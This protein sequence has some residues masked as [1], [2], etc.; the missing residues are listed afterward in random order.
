MVPRSATAQ[1][2]AREA[3]R[4]ILKELDR[5]LAEWNKRLDKLTVEPTQRRP[6]P[7]TI[8]KKK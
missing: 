4:N 1:S 7:R 2:L 5:I 3:D 6:R 8:A